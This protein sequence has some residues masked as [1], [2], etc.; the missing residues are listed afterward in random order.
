MASIAT[1]SGKCPF[2]HASGMTGTPP[3]NCPASNPGK[4]TRNKYW[5]TVNGSGTPECDGLYSPSTAPPT[6][7]ESGT[8]S[9]IGYWNGKLAWDRADGKAKRNPSFSYSNS[10]KAWRIARLDGHLA[11]TIVEDTTLP[12]TT[13]PWDVYKKGVG[14]APSI[15]IYETESEARAAWASFSGSSSGETK[16]N[17][18]TPNV[19]FVLGGPGA[20]KGT[21]CTLA[22]EQLVGFNSVPLGLDLNTIAVEHVLTFSFS[23]SIIFTLMS[24]SVS[25]SFLSL[26][27]SS[28]SFIVMLGRDGIIYLRVICCVLKEI[29]DPKMPI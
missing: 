7:S 15:A 29:L 4:C 8:T 12:T 20:G 11:Y 18:S 13:T 28:S 6:V 24:S 16:E 5:I 23:Y 1:T 14:P 26:S 21:M 3:A 22:S 2:K 10:Y 9:S 17:A 19:V 27:L 25:S